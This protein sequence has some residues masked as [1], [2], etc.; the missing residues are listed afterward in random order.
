MHISG[1]V[2][3]K[4]HRALYAVEESVPM[5]VADL[6]QVGRC[7]HGGERGGRSRGGRGRECTS[8]KIAVL[9]NI[10]VAAVEEAVQV[11]GSAPGIA[12]GE[13]VLSGIGH[14]ACVKKGR[15]VPQTC[16][17]Y[18][19]RSLCPHNV[20]LFRREQGQAENGSDHVY[21]DKVR[22]RTQ[23]YRMKPAQERGR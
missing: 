20:L 21:T 13:V 22:Q 9:L 16:V 1:L 12:V 6:F 17:D 11:I 7:A 19:D 10:M 8:R 5:G 15:L 18:H 2:R 14:D 3:V 23:Q 4:D